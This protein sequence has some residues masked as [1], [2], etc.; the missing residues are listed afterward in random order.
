M[1]MGGY[2]HFVSDDFACQVLHLVQVV[3]IVASYAEQWTVVENRVL[4]N[5]WRCCR[6]ER[7]HTV[8]ENILRHHNALGYLHFLY[9]RCNSRSWINNY[10]LQIKNYEEGPDSYSVLNQN[11]FFFCNLTVAQFFSQNGPPQYCR[12]SLCKQTLNIAPVPETL[13]NF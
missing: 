4:R 7:F 1:C 13:V 8:R 6:L 10:K 2:L 3:G 11:C 5:S 12:L 9:C